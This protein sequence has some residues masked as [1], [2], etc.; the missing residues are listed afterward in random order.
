MHGS[1]FES[2]HKA[3]GKECLPAEL[4]GDQPPYDP[5]H[6]IEFLSEVTVERPPPV[7]VSEV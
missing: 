3:I 6:L 7:K 2:L 1:D 4:G 5:E